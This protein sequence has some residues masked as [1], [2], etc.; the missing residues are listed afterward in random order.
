MWL[1]KTLNKCSSVARQGVHVCFPEHL[2]VPPEP[3]PIC[4]WLCDTSLCAGVHIMGRAFRYS[5]ACMVSDGLQYQ[6]VS[7][8]PSCW[9][10]VSGAD[11]RTVLVD[12]WLC[13]RTSVT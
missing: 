7:Y 9:G 13:M 8:S 10:G 5:V 6:V 12:C 2:P 11:V 1:H 3:A 4:A